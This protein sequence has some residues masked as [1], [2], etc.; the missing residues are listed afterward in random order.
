MNTACNATD[1]FDIRIIYEG[2]I[3]ANYALLKL[4][5]LRSTFEA[6]VMCTIL[7]TLCREINIYTFVATF[8]K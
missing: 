1:R 8:L 6:N 4:L 3:T 2:C 5:R 7:E